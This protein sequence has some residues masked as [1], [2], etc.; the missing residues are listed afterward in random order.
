[1]EDSFQSQDEPTFY[2]LL[3]EAYCL[4]VPSKANSGKSIFSQPTKNTETC[5]FSSVR[6]GLMETDI[7]KSNHSQLI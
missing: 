6:H 4:T 3:V 5:N 1:M 2:H 7:S